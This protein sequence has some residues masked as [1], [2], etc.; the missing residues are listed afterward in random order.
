MTTK[1]LQYDSSVY[2]ARFGSTLG[3]NTANANFPTFTAF[4]AMQAYSAT[5]HVVVAGT[6][7]AGNLWVI[8]Q[9]GGTAGTTTTALATATLGTSV[10]GVVLNV[11]LSTTSGG[12]SLNQ[13]DQLVVTKGTD[14]AG[15]SSCVLEVGLTELSNITA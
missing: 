4:T 3:A 9:I 2:Q 12:I 8:N 14:T 13:G 10:A 11:A 15:T 6:S 1:S 7:A 5:F